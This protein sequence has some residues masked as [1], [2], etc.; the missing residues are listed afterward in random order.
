MS[1]PPVDTPV[2][3][4]PLPVG[5]PRPA[6]SPAQQMTTRSS[7]GQGWAACWCWKACLGLTGAALGWEIVCRRLGA[8]HR[9]RRGRPVSPFSR[10]TRPVRSQN[11]PQ[12]PVP[13]EGLRLPESQERDLAGTLQGGRHGHHPGA[14]QRGRGKPAKRHRS[15]QDSGWGVWAWPARCHPHRQV[16]LRAEPGGWREAAG[17]ALPP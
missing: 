11:V 13:P 16:S 14:D 9:A 17:G 2:L 4:G 15:W 6:V 8:P 3:D 10:W 7:R 5:L 12:G 1:S